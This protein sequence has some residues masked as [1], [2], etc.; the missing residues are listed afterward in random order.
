MTSN[1]LLS[2]LSRED[3]G[4]LE[5]YLEAVDL[6]L[7]KQLQ[8]RNGRTVQV[9]FLESGVASIV[10]NGRH[11]IEVG[12]IGRDGMTG[13]AVVLGNGQGRAPHETYM[14]IAGCGLRLPA[15]RL[16]EA[17]AASVSLHQVLLSYVHVFLAQCTET[18]LANG[19]S[20]LEERLARWLLMAHDRIDGDEIALTHEFISVM[21]GVRRAGVTTA[22]HELERRGLIGN[23]RSRITIADRAGLEECASDIYSARK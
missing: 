9:Y 1:Q 13:L 23:Q 18:A 5:P 6:P 20:K 21:L 17:I 3:F 8:A 2:R 19:G 12:L 4:L 10:A 15:N 14:Q 22:L 7:R 16:R 11:P